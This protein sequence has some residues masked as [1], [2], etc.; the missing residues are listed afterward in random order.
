MTDLVIRNVS[1]Q[2]ILRIDAAARRLGLSRNEFLS[3]QLEQ[4]CGAPANDP[5]T[6]ADLERSVAAF[7]D[8]A[9]E[10]VMSEAWA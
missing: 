5:T 8:L 9:N 7:A 6:M 3:R 2:T 10:S 4:L 1:D